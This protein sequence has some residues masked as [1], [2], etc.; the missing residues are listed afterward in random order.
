[1]TDAERA[2]AGHVAVHVD[3]NWSGPAHTAPRPGPCRCCR[4]LARTLDGQ[5][6]HC[7]S[8]CAAQEAEQAAV[9]AATRVLTGGRP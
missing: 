6:C 5:G 9:A 4:H 2:L 1:M 7:H 8:S 3:L